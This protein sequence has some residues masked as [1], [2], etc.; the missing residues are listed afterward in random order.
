MGFTENYDKEKQ[1]V[2]QKNFVLLEKGAAFQLL[3][4]VIRAKKRCS[5]RALV[6]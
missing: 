1:A 2:R 4:Y 5:S 6:A 3:G